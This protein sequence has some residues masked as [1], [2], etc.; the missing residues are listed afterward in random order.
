LTEP[1]PHE[2]AVRIAVLETQLVNADKAQELQ[3]REYER[4]LQDLNHAHQQ[5]MERNATFVSRELYDSGVREVRSLSE[6]VR[7]ESRRDR[8]DTDFRINALSAK[9]YIGV[10]IVLALQAVFFLVLEFWRK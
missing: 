10:G 3:A 2:Y 7:T 4:R 8:D 1:S 6:A 5:A 9:I